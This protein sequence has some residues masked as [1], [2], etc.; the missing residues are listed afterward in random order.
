VAGKLLNL[1]G[2]LVHNV[3]SMA[4]VMI[5]DLLIADVDQRGEEHN[6]S[7]NQAHPPEWHNLDQIVGEKSSNASLY[8]ISFCQFY[9]SG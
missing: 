3:G 1:L 6:R 4:D 9:G 5:N 7:T 8:K 2:L